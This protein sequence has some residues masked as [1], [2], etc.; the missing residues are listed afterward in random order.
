MATHHQPFGQTSRR[1]SGGNHHQARGFKP[2]PT[3]YGKLLE[4]VDFPQSKSDIIAYAYAHG[5][6]DDVIRS[7]ECLPER[8]YETLTEVETELGKLSS[9]PEL[10]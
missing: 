7:L 6:G 9:E 4:G 3:D 8:V 1:T 10:S 2:A 5:G